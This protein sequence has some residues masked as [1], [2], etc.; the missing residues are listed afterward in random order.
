MWFHRSSCKRRWVVDED[1]ER[2]VVGREK[3]RGILDVG[4]KV[5]TC[6]NGGER[7]EGREVG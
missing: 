4:L 2:V 6:F 1:D 7:R 3:G 5:K